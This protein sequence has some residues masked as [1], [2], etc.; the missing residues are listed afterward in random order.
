[1]SRSVE[2][3]DFHYASKQYRDSG[4]VPHPAWKVK[5]VQVFITCY[6]MHF[7]FEKGIGQLE[8]L[9]QEPR[10]SQDIQFRF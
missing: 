8:K 1:M 2:A 4:L 7:N 10:A 5:L 3:I 9:N 6:S